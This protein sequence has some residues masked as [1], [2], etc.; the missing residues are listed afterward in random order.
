MNPAVRRFLR[1]FLEMLVAMLLGMA[2]AHPLIRP[3][4]SDA[5]ALA[6]SGMGLAMSAPMA[7]W[8][9]HRRKTWPRVAE[10][11][12]AMML[13]AA[14]LAPLAAAGA[15]ESGRSALDIQHGVM[16][17]SMLAAM[18]L[19]REAYTGEVTSA[20]AREA[21]TASEISTT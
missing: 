13:P 3:L 5:P 14:V 2:I 19:R 15:I 7:A 4:T 8:M 6:V 11:V 17:A 21:S 1:H 10:M 12:A 20:D 18:L 9:R 16:L